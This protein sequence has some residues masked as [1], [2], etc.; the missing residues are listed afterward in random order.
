MKDFTNTWKKLDIDEDDSFFEDKDDS[1]CM[2]LF[3]DSDDVVI[4][5]KDLTEMREQHIKEVQE[6]NK[7][8][9]FTAEVFGISVEKLKQVIPYYSYIINC[10]ERELL[11]KHAFYKNLFGDS[12]LELINLDHIN[13]PK[14]YNGFFSYKNKYLVKEKVDNLQKIFNLS[15]D[16]IIRLLTYSSYYLYVSK[17]YINEYI[18]F[19]KEFFN[20]GDKELIDIFIKYPRLIEV[21]ASS[22]RYNS[23][24]LCSYFG[25]SLDEVKEMYKTYPLSIYYTAY[26]INA[27]LRFNRNRTEDNKKHILKFPW[28]LQ[29]ITWERH[30]LNYCGLE[31]LPLLFDFAEGITK[32]FGSVV[33][34]IKKDWVDFYKKSWDDNNKDITYLLL[35]KKGDYFLLCIG[36]KTRQDILLNKFWGEESEKIFRVSIQKVSTNDIYNLEKYFVDSMISCGCGLRGVHLKDGSMLIEMPLNYLNKEGFETIAGVFKGN[37]IFDFNYILNLDIEHVKLHK[38]YY[39][40]KAENA[41]NV[42]SLDDKEFDFDISVDEGASVQDSNTKFDFEDT[43]NYLDKSTKEFIFSVFGGEKELLNYYNKS[44]DQS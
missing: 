17:Q 25:C 41:D 38:N 33:Y 24:K 26:N 12:L 7:R 2:P 8:V 31:S 28:V 27:D 36:A 4:T 29:C 32:T 43:N 39:T 37:V 16:G 34:V 11:D 22:I 9:A 10:K 44:I 42:S 23:E 18:H 3:E 14:H 35:E 1:F 40:Q 21:S 20:V 19:L 5:K 30:N 13:M 15:L 6:I